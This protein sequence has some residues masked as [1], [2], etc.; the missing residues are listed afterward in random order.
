MNANI[1]NLSKNVGDI[2]CDICERLVQELEKLIGANATDEKIN[3]TIYGLCDQLPGAAA[4]FNKDLICKDSITIAKYLLAFYG[5]LTNIL[6]VSTYCTNDPIP[7]ASSVRISNAVDVKCDICEFVINEFDKVLADNGTDIK[8]NATI[9]AAC[10]K[11]DGAAAIFVIS[12]PPPSNDLKC[13]LCEMIVLKVDN[14]VGQNASDEKINQ[15]VYKV[16]QELSGTM[17]T[18]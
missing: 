18:F 6:S 5:D 8:I 4:S 15:T 2:K 13:E 3:A 11:L 17:Q 16:C 9:F 14:F 12:G 10:D 7:K 1:P